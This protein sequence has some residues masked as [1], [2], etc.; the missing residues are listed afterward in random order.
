MGQFAYTERTKKHIVMKR[1]NFLKSIFSVTAVGVVAPSL[2]LAKNKPQ[3][4]IKKLPRNE[5]GY[6]VLKTPFGDVWLL[7][8]PLFDK[9]NLQIDYNK[10]ET[11][12]LNLQ[13]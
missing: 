12:Y 6:Y 1:R 8:H 7:E 5:H 10:I 13:S 9:V 3:L 4:N 2:L 11:V